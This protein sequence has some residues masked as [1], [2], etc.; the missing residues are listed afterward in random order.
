MDRRK[1]ILAATGIFLLWNKTSP[2]IGLLSAKA[3]HHA[4]V[5]TSHPGHDSGL[6]DDCSPTRG[7]IESRPVSAA[8]PANK[9]EKSGPEPANLSENRRNQLRGKACSLFPQRAS[10]SR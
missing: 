7:P 1:G 2:E 3:P 8:K 4:D 9:F 10:A 5:R 6:S